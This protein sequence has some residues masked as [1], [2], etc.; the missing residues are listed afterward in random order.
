MSVDLNDNP[1]SGVYLRHVVFK[2][3][4]ATVTTVGVNYKVTGMFGIEQIPAIFG[5]ERK[6]VSKFSISGVNGTADIAGGDGQPRV[7]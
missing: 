5:I 4:V 3:E 1:T 7:F 6:S 2:S